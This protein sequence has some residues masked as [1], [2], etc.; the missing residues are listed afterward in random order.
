MTGFT[1]G[2]LPSS[3]TQIAVARGLAESVAGTGI[4][5]NSIL[6]GPTKSRGVVEFVGALAKTGA[7]QL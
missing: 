1:I 7:K 6:P 2:L 3:G 4:T 5:V